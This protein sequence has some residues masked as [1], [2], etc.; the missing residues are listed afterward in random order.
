MIP[1]TDEEKQRLDT[2]LLDVDNL[3]EYQEDNLESLVST[4]DWLT[5]LKTFVRPCKVNT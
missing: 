1:M 2:L 3:P 5:A 4:D